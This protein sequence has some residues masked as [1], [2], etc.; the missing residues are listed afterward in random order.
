MTTHKTLYDRWLHTVKC[1]P[2]LRKD[3]RAA[4]KKVSTILNGPEYLESQHRRRFAREL[5]NLGYD[6]YQEVPM[7][8]TTEDDSIPFGHG[9]ID[10]LIKTDDGVI[11]L[12]L[13][14]TPKNCRKQLLRYMTHWTH[15]PVLFGFTVNFS[16][17]NVILEDVESITKTPRMEVDEG[18]RDVA[19][20][21]VSGC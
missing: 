12:E 7:V 11:I 2:Q 18:F 20:Q 17:D 14:V 15:T 19:T 13:K 4:A 10:I 16:S 21:T 1:Y 6:V 3:I 5:Q 9:F 8:F